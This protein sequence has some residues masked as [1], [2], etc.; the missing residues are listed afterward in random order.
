M[1]AV[2][3]PIPNP[4]ARL[5]LAGALVVAVTTGPAL[6]LPAGPHV[7]WSAANSRPLS[8][9]W[10]PRRRTGLVRHVAAEKPT[11]LYSQ[12][13][14][15]A[16]EEAEYAADSTPG[17]GDEMVGDGQDVSDTQ[18]L[19]ELVAAQRYARGAG[20]GKRRGGG[21]GRRRGWSGRALRKL[22]HTRTPHTAR[23]TPHHGRALRSPRRPP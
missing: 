23:R 4:A 8:S 5:A 13:Y 14:G 16:D 9:S 21:A 6:A 2:T 7:A 3:M 1:V 10:L 19:S 12:W 17:A 20:M 11:G 18:M 22:A 15:G